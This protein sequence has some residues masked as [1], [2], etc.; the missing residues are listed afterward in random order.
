[1]YLWFRT[2]ADLLR[3]LLKRGRLPKSELLLLRERAGDAPRDR[4]RIASYNLMGGGL[5]SIHRLADEL[6]KIDADVVSLQEVDHR[7]ERSG[8]V[9]QTEV[10]AEA[11][12]MSSVFCGA[13]RLGSGHYGNALLSR[14]PILAAERIAISAPLDSNP[15]AAIDATLD[16]HGE[17]LR[18][19]AAHLDHL[20]W[21]A[22]FSCWRLA[23]SLSRPPEERLI[24]AGDLN[25]PPWGRGPQR[26]L[27][28]GLVDLVGRFDEGPTF[29]TEGHSFRLDY[30]LVD[31]ELA[32]R[33]RWG[34]R[35]V[36]QASD[37]YPVVVELSPRAA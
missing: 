2:S 22:T 6:A 23:L 37:H 30:V 26:L 36:T 10:L 16:W 32:K 20:P 5:S 17:R 28:A 9:D 21:A 35:I 25:A 1:M 4:L 3:A 12:G 8:R 31:R 7:S 24:V 27:R 14:L 18:V 13:I 33:A 15:R 34:Q 19:I 11:L 29:H